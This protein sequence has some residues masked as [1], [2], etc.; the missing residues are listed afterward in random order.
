MDLETL[1]A[2][3]IKEIDAEE[4]Q[5]SELSLKVHANP[6]LGFREVKATAWLTQYLKRNGFFVEQGICEL[7]TAFKASYGQGKPAT[8]ILAEY[9]ALLICPPIGVISPICQPFE[10][11]QL[12]SSLSTQ[13]P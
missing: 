7:P 8:A 5:L 3:V 13:F 12:N 11:S 1:K 4:R 2:L 10:V 9:D 6:E